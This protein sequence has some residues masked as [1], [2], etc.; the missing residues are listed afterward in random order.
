MSL[1]PISSNESA[2]RLRTPTAGSARVDGRSTSLRAGLRAKARS[3]SANGMIGKFAAKRRSVV[4]H[5]DEAQILGAAQEEGLLA[6]H[7]GTLGVPVLPVLTGL[8]H[9]ETALK[10][11]PGMSR[12]ADGSVVN[13]G[14]M[15]ADECAESTLSLL[16]ALGVVA[17]PGSLR[18]WAAR[19]ADLSRGWPQH[20]NR[21]QAALCR[22]L[23][24]TGGRID[25]VDDSAVEG[26]SD[27]ARFAYYRS[28][29]DD[30][31]L[32]TR[33]G[34]AAAFAE[35]LDTER[36]YDLM[37]LT[38]LCGEEMSALG[39]DQGRWFDPHDYVQALIERGVLAK[40]DAD[41]YRMAIPSM[42]NWLVATHGS[43]G[44][45]KRQP[46]PRG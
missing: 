34:L 16:D 39:I 17:E 10:A 13:M 2:R 29:M 20:L 46:P 23:A 4:V 27:Q 8:S 11:V 35:R 12:L 38:D 30:P 45:R 6:M 14:G 7:Q 21:V 31:V 33:P 22:E 37:A 28:R 40:D 1:F 15:S 26:Q 32:A 18:D 5:V 9:T 19:I 43:D 41:L 44:G 42:R 25:A 24:R 36:P 3:A